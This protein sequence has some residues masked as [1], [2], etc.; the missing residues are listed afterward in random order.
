MARRAVWVLFFCTAL[1]LLSGAPWAAGLPKEPIL[2][3]ETGM[4]TALIKGAAV[5]AAGRWLVT[6]SDD[7]SLRVWDLA[8]GDPRGAEIQA[9]VNPARILRP[10]I[11]AGNEGKLFAVA[12]SPDGATVAC[13]GWTGWDWDKTASVY[14]FD[15]ASGRLLK[16]LD[17]FPEVIK[18]LAYSRD[19]KKLAVALGAGKGVY[20]VR[21]ADY[22]LAG[23][24]VDYRSDCYGLDFDREGRLATVSWDGLVRLYDGSFKLVAKVKAPNGERPYS[25]AFSADGGKIAVGCD[26]SRKV[27]VLSG[28][29]LTPLYTPP[30]GADGGS[31]FSVA[32]SADGSALYAAGSYRNGQKYLVRRWEEGGKGRYADFP[33]ADGNVMQ[34]LP[35]ANGG[36]AYA[37]VGPE[38]GIVN[39]AGAAD[40][41][42][43]S[44]VA[45]YADR[46]L[47]L[48]GDGSAVG[49]GYGQTG[50][51]RAVF[52]VADRSLTTAAPPAALVPPLLEAPGL[53]VT[54]WRHATAPL[55]NG[56]RLRL[57]EHETARSLAVAPNGSGFLLGT[58]WYLRCYDRQ[59]TERWRVAA[60][61]IAWAVNIAANGKVAVA[62]FGDG[63]IRWHRLADGKELLAFFPHADGKR[64]VLWTPSGYYDASV[65]GEELAGW[66]LNNGPDQ[67]ADFFPVAR[68]RAVFCRPDIINR[69]LPAGDEAEAV[70][71]SDAAAG[72]SR[73]ARS[74]LA[75]LPPLV[76]ISAPADKSV[77]DGSEAAVAF[78]VRSPSGEPVTG[79][80]VLVNGRPVPFREQEKGG[81]I[82]R[83][84]LAL[85]EGGSEIAVI[86]ENRH[87]ASEPATVRVS[88]AVAQAAS[89]EISL[90]PRLF[91]LAVGVGAYP[92]KDLAL[93][94]AAKDAKDFAALM[95]RQK[96]GLYGEATARILTDA[97]ATR[98]AVLDGLAWLRRA[99]TDR[100]TAVVFLSGHGITEPNGT[101]Y[102]LPVNGQPEKL[103]GTAVVFSEIRNTL[104]SL[105]GKAVLFVDTC[106]AGDVLGGRNA[107]SDV[108][109][110]VNELS[111]AENGVVVFASST[112][113][114]SSL[115]DASWGNGAFT[116]ALVEGVTGKADY[117]GRGRITVTS[118][119]LWLS[120]RVAELTEGRQTPTTAKPRTIPDFPLALKR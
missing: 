78:T 32:W 106:H 56:N 27:A 85:P 93:D 65:G 86:A 17:G 112:G 60:P 84:T 92:D 41:H 99:A 90:Q 71:L 64:W 34:L 48:A 83:V 76:A 58:D 100:D 117:T 53:R 20:L 36:I 67:A 40:F 16:R 110:M 104:M 120:D 111:S 105:P 103:A 94:F 62:A 108:S 29:D 66:H 7:K 50:T 82:H 23:L 77:I 12:I 96:G 4:H 98:E 51:S 70:R 11:G 30:G 119:D 79:V 113:G 107:A 101:Y 63:S 1:Q 42:L 43:G 24:D 6:A 59:G 31:L 69:V 47:L 19:G 80:R 102:Y 46:P 61:G 87:A 18:A 10:P 37:A 97:G 38:I 109:S 13:G 115:E 88:R 45:N 33:V 57:E 9:A 68:F 74:L 72:R 49:F 22:R 116:K 95:L 118:L 39:A 35:L 81:A 21:T 75:L 3:I 44:C 73:E 28:A 25:V 52:A 55:L 54:N 5:D 8:G 26:D 2:R 14:F 114:Q 91:I 15:R 89:E